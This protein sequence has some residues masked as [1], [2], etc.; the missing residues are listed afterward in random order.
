MKEDGNETEVT[1][2]TGYHGPGPLERL[3]GAEEEKRET[4]SCQ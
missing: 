2:T 1:K 3:P 4:Q